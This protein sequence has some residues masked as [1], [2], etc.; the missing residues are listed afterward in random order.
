MAVLIN[1]LINPSKLKSELVRI[2]RSDFLKT[3]GNMLNRLIILITLF[4]FGIS[5]PL[6]ISEV[7]EGSSN[8]KYLE[9][10]NTGGTDV[11]LSFYSLSS[12]SNGCDVEGEWDYPNNVTFEPGTMLAAGDVYVVCHGSADETIQAECDQTFTYLSNGDDA[13]ALTYGG[14]I[15]DIIGDTGGDPGSGWQICD[16]ENATKDHTIVRKSWVTEG[17]SDWGTSSG[18]DG[19]DCQW[20]V[21]DQNDWTFLGFHD[22]GETGGCEVNG[23]V[24]GDGILNVLDV[25]AI[26]SAITSSTTDELECADM[27]DDG[28]INVLDVVSIVSTIV[29]GRVVDATEA[30]LHQWDNYMTIEADGYIGA[31]QM[32]LTHGSDFSIE[33]TDDAFVADYHTSDNSTTLVIVVPEE[34]LFVCS[35]NYVIEETLVVNSDSYIPFTIIDE[36]LLDIEAPQITEFNL[37]AA[38]PNPFN[39]STTFELSIPE[40]GRI[41]VKVFDLSG[42]LVEV[43]ANDF[44]TSDT[45]TMTWN[46]NN[47]PSGMYVIHAEFNGRSIS[48]NV[49]LIK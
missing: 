42:S 23:D 4:S 36:S 7:A 30:S 37:S 31:V 32:T 24:N 49:M 3:G 34:E 38:Y 18:S 25:V 21:L 45:Y 8:N 35:G 41:S 28:I 48:H 17:T 46:A 6:L 39:P 19:S 16:I 20:V 43:L 5:A 9:I 27:N 33:L 47:L 29:G 11:D 15:L 12:C 44:Y 13:F 26:V 22:M 2:V 14:T 1:L 10:F 40:A